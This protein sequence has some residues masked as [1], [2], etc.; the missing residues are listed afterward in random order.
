MNEAPRK[1]SIDR[2]SPVGPG[3]APSRPPQEPHADPRAATI[4]VVLADSNGMFRQ[5]LAALLAAHPEVEVLAQVADGE[6]AW[7]AI[8]TREPDI[9]I[10]DLVLTKA[11]GIEVTRRVAA[12]ARDTRCLM[13]ATHEDPDLASQALRAGAAGY[14]L[15]HSRFEEL[16]L[17]LRSI[18]AGGTFISPSIATKLRA[19]QRDGRDPVT[20]SPREREVVRLLAVG[21]RTKEIARALG[22]SPHTVDTHRRRLMKKLRLGSAA[23]VVRYAAQSGL[24]G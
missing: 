11:T 19:L 20:L 24:L 17:A 3:A 4:G 14:V 12:A 6:A 21:K 9:A 18:N 1:P 22:I 15:K 23:E 10:L 7:Q 5:G 13:L 8:Q 16:M 2:G